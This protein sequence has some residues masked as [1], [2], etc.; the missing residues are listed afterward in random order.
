M[1]KNAYTKGVVLIRCDGCNNLHLIADHL[2]WYDSQ[3]PPGSIEDIMK[4]KGEEVVRLGTNEVEDILRKDGKQVEV[5]ENG[6]GLLEVLDE[7]VFEFVKV[8]KE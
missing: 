8:D 7:S 5:G 6:E 1:S 3:N 4:R 2:G